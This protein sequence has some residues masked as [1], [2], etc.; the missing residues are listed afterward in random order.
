MPTK[1]GRVQ[2]RDIRQGKTY[3]TVV[4]DPIRQP[5]GEVHHFR[6]LGPT[7]VWMMAQPYYIGHRHLH[8]FPNVLHVWVKLL[9]GDLSDEAIPAYHLG[10]EPP[11]EELAFDEE[12]HGMFIN[13]Q[14]AIRYL[15]HLHA[16]A[17]VMLAG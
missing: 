10:L 5:T 15:A 12:Y 11:P 14:S 7:P 8:G 16:I 13:E 6:V 3:W 1:A 17:P 2:L 4:V 9:T